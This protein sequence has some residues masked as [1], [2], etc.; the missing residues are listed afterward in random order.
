MINTTPT[1]ITTTITID[2]IVAAVVMALLPFEWER[3]G[4]SLVQL[5]L[6]GGSITTTAVTLL[7]YTRAVSLTLVSVDSSCIALQLK[8]LHIL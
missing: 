5:H 8:C 6:S 2:E 7:I 3:V 1:T 4:G